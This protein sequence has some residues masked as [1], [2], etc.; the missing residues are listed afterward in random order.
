METSQ[1]TEIIYLLSSDRLE[2]RLRATGEQFLTETKLRA[3]SL[4]RRGMQLE[5]A[6]GLLYRG[7]LYTKRLKPQEQYKC[8]ATNGSHVQYERENSQSWFVVPQ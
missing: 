8:Y 7:L 4:N 3:E 2:I 1:T 5:T 6:Q